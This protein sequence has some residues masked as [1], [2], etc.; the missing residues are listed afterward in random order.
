MHFMTGKASPPRNNQHGHDMQLA[1]TTDDR[2]GAG[3]EG[4][5]RPRKRRRETSRSDPG[6]ASRHKFGTASKYPTTHAT[7]EIGNEG[8]GSLC[9]T[10]VCQPVWEHQGT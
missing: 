7:C 3:A 9:Q 4:R 5:L 8:N 1:R 2:G 6:V 10:I